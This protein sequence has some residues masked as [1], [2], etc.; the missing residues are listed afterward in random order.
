MVNA[1]ISAAQSTHEQPDG[2]RTPTALSQ[3]ESDAEGE[4]PVQ[5]VH[6]PPSLPPPAPAVI[7][8]AAAATSSAPAE[9]GEESSSEDPNARCDWNGRVRTSGRVTVRV[10]PFVPPVEIVCHKAKWLPRRKQGGKRASR[11]A[12]TEDPIK[13][14]KIERRKHKTGAKASAKASA[15]TGKRRGRPAKKHTAAAIDDAETTQNDESGIAADESGSAE[16]REAADADDG[17]E[18]SGEPAASTPVEPT[19]EAV[20]VLDA[21]DTGTAA[22]ASDSAPME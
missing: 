11:A 4:N 7:A 18:M 20:N 6:T 15:K 10:V 1:L 13:R 8:P 14:S 2:T 9:D 12:A 19:D 21:D 16:T 3:S 22:P 5:I 17:G